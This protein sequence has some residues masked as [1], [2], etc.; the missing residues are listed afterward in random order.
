MAGAGDGADAIAG[1][2]FKATEGIAGE[3]LRSGAPV[4][5]ADLSHDP[6]FAHDVAV[7][8][9]Y[10]PDAM[11]VVPVR[12]GGRIAGVLSVLDPERTDTRVLG[13]LAEHAATVLRLAHADRNLTGFRLRAGRATNWSASRIR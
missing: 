10:D 2:R 9:G 1:A 8:T 7:A 11:T 4:S 12:E 6:R 3:V 13:L 5:S